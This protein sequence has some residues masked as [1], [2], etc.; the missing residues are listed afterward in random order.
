MSDLQT[1]SGAA[2]AA[3][4]A[5]RTYVVSYCLEEG[6]TVQIDA[7]NAAK[8]IRIVEH[9]LDEEACELPKS[10]RVHF[11]SLVLD[12]NDIP[13]PLFDEPTANETRAH[14]AATACQ[15]F[16][17]QTG[18]GEGI[19]TL[20]D[21]I[22]DLGHLAETEGYDFLDIVERAIGTWHAERTNPQGLSP[23]PTVAIS[24]GGAA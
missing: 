13:A 17:E 22:A 4:K 3:P 10:T 7:A 9:F 24:I 5:L 15:T 6:F 23:A 11:E 21:L 12:A 20:H 19:D 16:I 2:H 1:L 8:A 18:C 14:W